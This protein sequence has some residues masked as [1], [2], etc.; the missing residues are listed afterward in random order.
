MPTID[1]SQRYTKGLKMAWREITASRHGFTR[2]LHALAGKLQGKMQMT[3]L[4][5]LPT[6]ISIEL[7]NR[8]ACTC[9]L[10]PV[11]QRIYSRR[12]GNMS[13]KQ[14]TWLVD[15]VSSHARFIGLYNWGDP[16]LHPR[17][18]DM[19]SYVASKKI[20][21]KVSSTLRNWDPEQAE[22]LVRTGLDDLKVSLHGASEETYRDYQPSHT[23]TDISFTDALEKVRAIQLAKLRLGLTKPNITLGFIV[24]RNNEHEIDEFLEIARQ[25]GVDYSLEE[26]SLNLRFLPYDRMMRSK[27][28][29]EASLQRERKALTERWLPKEDRYV[30]EYYRFIRTHHG[31]LPPANP[32]W[33]SCEWPWQQTVISSNGDVNLCCG[34]YAINDRIGNVFELPL[35]KIWNNALYRAARRNI[36]CRTGTNTTHVLCADCPGRLL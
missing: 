26:T 17:V 22:R 9:A 28:L 10:C 27:D 21:V 18:Y 25:L 32:K 12:L 24:T 29:D 23:R 33:F 30:N 1:T 4:L 3:Y 34:S 2:L 6:Y 36:A 15:Q 11:G 13:W 8:C 14:F 31:F 7:T 16:F 5:G 20:Y 19:I 35:R